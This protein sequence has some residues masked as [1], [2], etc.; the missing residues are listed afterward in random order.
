VEHRQHTHELILGAQ[1]VSLNSKLQGHVAKIEKH[2]RDLKA[3]GKAIS[4]AAR[5]TLTVDAFCALKGNPNFDSLI[6]EADLALA[7]AKSAEAVKQQENFAVLSLPAFDTG[8]IE[9]LLKRDLPDLE[10]RATE[11]TW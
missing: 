6:Q 1:G 8:E 4:S 11:F 5:G 2:N 10:T 3:K 7:A 9:T